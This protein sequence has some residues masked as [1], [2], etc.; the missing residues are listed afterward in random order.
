MFDRHNTKQIKVGKINIGHSDDVII[1]S[2]CNTKTYDT[3]NTIKQIN[4]LE[5]V[6]CQLVRVSVPDVKS[7]ESIETIKNNINIPLVA[8]IHYDYKLAL[9]CIDRGIDK[10]RIN[11]GNIG[12]EY[13]IKTL[14]DAC[15]S[16]NIPIRI[17]VNS[18]SL[19]KK[20]LEKFDGKVTAKG[21]FLSAKE[22]I[23]LLEKY[24]FY[25]TIVSIKSSNVLMM[26]EAYK[27][28]ADTYNYPLH[29]GVTE[30]GTLLSGS[31]KSSVG[32][33]ILLNYGLGDT[34]RVSLSANPIEE[35]VVAKKIL[36][37]LNLYN[38]GFE[39]I[40]CPTCARTKIDIIKITKEVEKSLDYLDSD[41]LI[42]VAIMGC[43]VNGPGEAIE[44]DIGIAGGDGEALLFKKGKII[45][46]IDENNIV[47]ILL[48]NINEILK[49]DLYE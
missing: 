9:M 6:G 43:A 3:T 37:S 40:S 27:M 34:I 11:P 35:I 24:N 49:E 36:R 17:G 28:F 5:K 45:K 22:N 12:D 44:A 18:G 33:G 30:A 20:I 10:I 25:D 1:Q 16:K 4:E 19:N 39:V 26:V 13:K 8:D 32:L 31:I 46:K 48:D 42:K 14:V 47:D 38:N 41:R 23:E 15:K 2:M 29:L 21:L 7:A